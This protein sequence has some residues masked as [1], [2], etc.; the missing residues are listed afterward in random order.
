MKEK[1]VKD[2]AINA[3]SFSHVIFDMDG[4]ILGTSLFSYI[5][6]YLNLNFANCFI[7]GS[8]DF[9]YIE[10]SRPFGLDVLVWGLDPNYIIMF[11]HNF[12]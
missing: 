7:F 11:F 9:L 5:S 4:L 1:S 6:I 3:D 2:A 12:F 10:W 8:V